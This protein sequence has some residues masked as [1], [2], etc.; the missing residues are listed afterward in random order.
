MKSLRKQI[1]DIVSEIFVKNGY[2]SE[3]GQVS[4]SDRPDLGQFQCNGGLAAAKKYKKNPREVAQQIIDD[5][6]QNK[7]FKD[8]SMAGPGFINLTVVDDYLIKHLNLVSEDKRLG[9]EKAAK[10]ERIVID[11]GGANIAKPLH[12]GHLRSAIIGESLKRMA[13]F[14]GARVWGDVHLGDWGLQMGMVILELKN[15]YPDLPYFDENYKGEY[16]LSPPFSIAELEEI[17]PAISAKAKKDETIMEEA[18]QATYELQQGR[19]GYKA[20]WQ[21]IF[22]TSV[23][24]LKLDY[25]ALNI[26]FDLWL[27]ESDTQDRI[28]GLIEKLSAAGSAVKSEGALVVHVAQEDDKK[29]IPPLMLVKSDG[30]ILYGTTDLAAVEQRIQDFNPDKI[31]YVVDLRQSDHFCQLFRAARKTGIA[32][33]SLGL[34][35]IG[36]GTMNSPDGKPFKTREGGIMKLKDLIQMITDKARERM[37]EADIASDYDQ[38]EKEDITRMV[39]VAALKFADLMNQ[40]GKNYV[41]DLDRFASFEGKTGPYLL[42]TAVRIKSILRKAEE[43]DMALGSLLSPAG[44]L[45]RNI[46]LKLIELPCVIELAFQKRMPNYLC[47]YVYNLASL[48]S[49]FYHECHILR[50]KDIEQ[51]SSWLRLLVLCLSALELVLDLLGIEVPERM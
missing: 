3:Y 23:N 10:E 29:D 33:E 35:H 20:L 4:I 2:E 17:Y 8:V 12:V 39:G 9:C 30:A 24:D 19:A 7:I 41:F 27:G 5:L 38:K 14:L 51:R 43:R 46:M 32:P 44:D 34:E 36:F 25:N 37:I 16:P 6:S 45:E 26:E 40:P 22:N 18:R 31:L 42:Y 21:H 1:A 48:F 50:E 28:P 47:D 15:R 11:Y 49:S 13:V